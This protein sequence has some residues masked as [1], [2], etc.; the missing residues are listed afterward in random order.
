MKRAICILATS[1]CTIVSIF[2]SAIADTELNKM[3]SKTNDEQLPT[4][5]IPQTSNISVSAGF[6]VLYNISHLAVK[7]IF[8]SNEDLTVLGAAPQAMVEIN[9]KYR[10][11]NSE[12]MNLG[13]SV[14]L[15]LPLH[16]GKII[17]DELAGTEDPIAH[18][19]N[20][21]VTPFIFLEK[22]IGNTTHSID[23]GAGGMITKAEVK[24]GDFT[25]GGKTISNSGDYLSCM[26]LEWGLGTKINDRTRLTMKVFYA[27]DF[28]KKKFDDAINTW[29]A[30]TDSLENTLKFI[31]S[32]T[33][34]NIEKSF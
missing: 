20:P 17:N 31:L 6:G 12:K 27:N 1:V 23:I 22:K 28:D 2:S 13:V 11:Y 30:G 32:G 9:T 33:I 26:Y 16:D 18:T 7:D 5:S 21:M 15:M 25:A 24:N 34:F 8:N 3:I 4:T 10:F 14:G 19:A 29:G